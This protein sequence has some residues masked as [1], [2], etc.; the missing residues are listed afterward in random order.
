M[1]LLA[2]TSEIPPNSLYVFTNTPL[3]SVISQ[4]NLGYM[5]FEQ[6]YICSFLLE[7]NAWNMCILGN[8]ENSGAFV[9][10]KENYWV[11]LFS[12]DES[13]KCGGCSPFMMRDIY[14]AYCFRCQ[15]HL[16]PLVW[17]LWVLLSVC[18]WCCPNSRF[19]HHFVIPV[20]L[21]HHIADSSLLLMIVHRSVKY[22]SLFHLHCRLFIISYDCTR[23]CKV[24]E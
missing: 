14:K 11:F 16:L 21:F 10:I 4:N 18:D 8:G 20:S 5:L 15:H 12:V 24:E 2:K 7:L 9:E 3:P 6:M 13:I 23:K 1:I 19:V 17:K 22:V